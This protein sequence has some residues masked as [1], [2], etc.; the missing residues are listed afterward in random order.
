MKVKDLEIFDEF[1]TVQNE[2]VL[3]A[4]KIM[5]KKNVPDL[6]L[7][8]SNKKPIGIISSEDIV[9]K[10]IAEDKDPKQVKIS[11]I[12]RKVKSFSE[13]ATMDEVLD[14]MMES[15]NELVPIIKADGTLLGVCTITDVA[16]EEEE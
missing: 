7:V 1:A 9:M 13:D 10:I 12:S 2:T 14:Y 4:A 6:V 3:E 5:K 8:D 15:E 16:W 11:D